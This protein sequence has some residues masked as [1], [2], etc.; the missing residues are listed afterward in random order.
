MKQQME[1]P[2]SALSSPL[3]LSR[4]WVTHGMSSVPWAQARSKE[5]LHGGKLNHE[6][7]SD[8]SA[9]KDPNGAMT[10]CRPMMSRAA[11]QRHLLLLGLLSERH[12]SVARILIA[13]IAEGQQTPEH[14]QSCTQHNGR[15]F[16]TAHP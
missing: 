13:A 8:T 10:G 16:A 4:G 9:L 7:A 12:T 6:V 2:L 5:G 15:R 14:K 3:N 11:Q 1:G